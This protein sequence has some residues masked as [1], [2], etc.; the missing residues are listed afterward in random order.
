VNTN[1]QLSSPVTLAG[2]AEI[3]FLIGPEFALSLPATEWGLLS[4]PDCLGKVGELLFKASVA[5]G[6][7]N[8]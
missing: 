4:F 7:V 1:E 8:P 6:L 5:D 3:A 2:P